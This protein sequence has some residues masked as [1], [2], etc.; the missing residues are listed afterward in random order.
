MQDDRSNCG[1]CGNICAIDQICDGGHCRLEFCKGT[2]DT[3]GATSDC[4]TGQGLCAGGICTCSP[5]SFPVGGDCRVDGDCCQGHCIEGVC[6][7]F[8]PDF[9][10]AP[11]ANGP[12]IIDRDCCSGACVVDPVFGIGLCTCRPLGS[13]CDNQFQCCSGNCNDTPLG[14]RLCSPFD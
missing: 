4:C 1:S 6:V 3:C 9:P 14:G 11:V 2:G 5:G 12:C 10:P 7:C 8:P 13:P